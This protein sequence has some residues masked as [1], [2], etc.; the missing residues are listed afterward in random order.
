MTDE[1]KAPNQLDLSKFRVVEPEGGKLRVYANFSQLSWTGSDI[2]VNLYHLE[3]PNREI[4][5]SKDDPTLLVQDVSVTMSWAAAKQFHQF[6]GTIL[7][8]YEKAYG[9]INTEFKQI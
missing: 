4:P 1:S 2:T 3:Q 9:P 6:L 7:E 8:R 5:H